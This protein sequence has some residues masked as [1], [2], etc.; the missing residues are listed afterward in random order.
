[1]W[2]WFWSRRLWSLRRRRRNSKAPNEESR[3]KNENREYDDFNPP[4]I[5]QRVLNSVSKTP[6]NKHNNNKSE[7]NDER[8]AN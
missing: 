4:I 6:E 7:N 1:L 3:H 8:Y 2:R 5:H